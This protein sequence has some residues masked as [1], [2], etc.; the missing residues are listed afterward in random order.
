[1][2]SL[3]SDQYKK[4]NSPDELLDLVDKNDQVIGVINREVANKDPKYTHREVAIIL[5]DSKN[6]LLIQ[7]RSEYKS[8]HPSMWSLTAG[9]ISAGEDPEKTA[10]IE[11]EE[12]LGLTGIKLKFLVKKYN[13]YS[14]ESHFKYYFIGEY[15]GEK[16]NFE[17]A[18]L[19]EVKFV[20]ELDLEI[21]IK[22]KDSINLKHLPILKKIWNKTYKV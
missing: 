16:I 20:S 13:E 18:E 8:V 21:M 11:L 7:K 5:V 4:A 1:M 12:E 9:H 22:N 19:S 3:Q 17:E 2:N 15:R 6:N 14:N 10:Y